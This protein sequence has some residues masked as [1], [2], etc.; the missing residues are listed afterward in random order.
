MWFKALTGFEEKSP[1]YVKENIEIKGEYLI[2]K[3]NNK[4]FCFGRLEIPTLTE[5][6][7]SIDLPQTKSNQISIKEVI[8]NVQDLHADIQNKN[9]VFQVASQFNLLEM[10][11]PHITPEQGVDRYEHDKTQGPICA[12]TCGAGT[13][14]RNYF[15]EVNKLIGQTK[16]NQIDCLELIGKALQNQKFGYWTMNN[17][18]A[19]ASQEGLC[20]INKELAKLSNQQREELK[21][22]LKVGIQWG[23]EVTISEDKH[24]VTQVYC[25]ALPVAYSMVKSTYWENFAQIIL[26]ATYEATLY[27]AI[28]NKQETGCNLVYLTLVGGGAFGNKEQW[29]FD[30]IEKAFAKFKHS[31]LDVRIVSHRK[32][33]ARLAALIEGWGYR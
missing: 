12:I 26:E 3:M 5:L 4:R 31:N 16:N 15:I 30:A 27:A 20:A 10:V 18:Y 25:S 24:K 32:S 33:K 7:N 13:I 23:T 17:G 28:K 14:Y 2:S 22:K 9:A 21:G 8:G 11:S 1:Q 29:I 19:L 6:R